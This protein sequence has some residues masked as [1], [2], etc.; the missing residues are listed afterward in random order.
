MAKLI[1]TG[2]RSIDEARRT[3]EEL[4]FILADYLTRIAVLEGSVAAGYAPV[5][6]PFVTIGN[7]ANLTAERRLAAGTGISLTDGGAN[8][9]ATIASLITQYTDA[10]VL[11]LLTN[12]NIPNDLTLDNITQITTRSHT[13]LSDIG[14]NTH[15]QIDT[16]L[17]AANPHSGSQPLDAL[18]TA[19][20]AL[21]TAADKLPYFTGVDAVAL[22][23]LSAFARTILDDANAAAV[24]ATLG[25]VPGTD[26]QAFDGG[27]QSLAELVITRGALLYGTAVNTWLQLPSDANA[28]RYLSNTGSSNDPAWAQVNLA[29]GVT[30]S[31]P[32][33][34]V[35]N[36]VSDLAAKLNAALVSAAALTVLDDATVAAMV[37]TLGGASS[38]GT[39][40]LVRATSPTLVTPALG[41]PTALVLTAATG[42][43]TAGLLDDAVTFAKMQ[44]ITTNR[45]LG[46]DTAATGNVEEI[47]LG[48][49]MAFDGSQVLQI[50]AFTGDV[51]KATGGTVLTIARSGTII[52]RPYLIKPPASSGAQET[53]IAGGSTPAEDMNVWAFDQTGP[54]YL[55]LYCLLDPK[56]AG[57]GLTIRL[58]WSGGATTNNVR[59][60]AAIRR[61]ADDA[62]Q[63]S[64]SHTYDYN[65]SSD[66]AAPSA[67]SE[68][69]YDT[70]AFTSGADMDSL[71]AGEMFILRIRR[72]AATSNMAADA[73]LWKVEIRET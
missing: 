23:D 68:N 67:L 55:D 26:I 1:N 3:F 62:E 38:T 54:E 36:L 71:A 58:I 49:D 70:I 56:F 27:L 42:L 46:R 28:T 60:G 65:D 6:E 15:A 25:L 5:G 41:T 48:S 4:A 40:G 13:S 29:N 47:A 7:T 64:A 43:P 72:T 16:H 11:A 59:W 24:Q 21:V 2:V 22:A 63:L 57:G 73:Y 12:A 20:A 66:V 31:L 37:D 32:Q 9:A 61:F 18:L 17:A 33:A 34:S 53:S 14:T 69:S 19:L 44:N 50:A 45:L 8:G 30:G 52:A 35:T 51:T 10:M 39:G